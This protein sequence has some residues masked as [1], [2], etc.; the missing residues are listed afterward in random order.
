[1]RSLMNGE[2][3]GRE[4]SAIN[5]WRRNNSDIAGKF[6]DLTTYLSRFVHPQFIYGGNVLVNA[7]ASVS[8]KELGLHLGL[9][10][11][12]VPGL[13]V[14]EHAEFGKEVNTYQ[15]FPDESDNRPEDRI[16]I[17]KIFDLGHITDKIVE[18]NNRSLNMHTFITG[19]TGSGKSNAVYQM[20]TELRQDKIPFLV[21]EPAKGEYKDVFGNL[22]D[23]HVY[24][25][26]PNIAPLVN[27]NPF[28]FP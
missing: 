5:S 25:T 17:G 16:T 19:S 27:I 24:S 8:G 26:N 7:A 10:R 11:A 21:I 28:K 20:L 23:V 9:P 4:V 13:P 14:I 6:T 1:Y 22:P 15:L 3:S 2:N 12:T 18:L